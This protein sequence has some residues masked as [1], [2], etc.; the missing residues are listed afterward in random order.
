MKSGT[1]DVDA[2]AFDP[3]EG[4]EA[5]RETT[6]PKR[7]A[8]GPKEDRRARPTPMLSRYTL[9][10]RRR[11]GRREGETENVY[12]DRPGPYVIT[13][14]FAIT[15]LSLLDATCTLYELSRGGTE[16]NPIMR[17]ALELGNHGFVF[18]KTILTVV[19]AAFLCLHKNW[20]L[21][22]VSLWVAIC[23][24]TALT[25]WHLYGLLVILPPLEG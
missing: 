24:Y 2:S 12:V 6:E 11:R 1:R 9:F 20:K 21:G 23:G 16:A 17:A 4:G 8:R 18:L 13:A 22:R 25:A 7:S 3:G 14:F 5:K 10:G 15:A 19:G